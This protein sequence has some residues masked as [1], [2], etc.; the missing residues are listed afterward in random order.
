[1]SFLHFRLRSAL[2]LGASAVALATAS[3]TAQAQTPDTDAFEIQELV[4]TAEKREQALQDVPVAVSAFTS[5]QRD[6]MGVAGIQ[7]FVNFTP[8]MNYSGEIGRASC[9]ERVS[10]CV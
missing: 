10:N 3:S 1:M 9:R 6:V 7:D 4:I 8:G 5:N 2:A